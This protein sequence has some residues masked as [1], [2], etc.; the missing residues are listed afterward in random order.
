MSLTEAVERLRGDVGTQVT[1]LVQREG[2]KDPLEFTIRR[3]LISIDSV[4]AELMDDG[5]ALLKI[6]NFQEDTA[7]ELMRS[8]EQLAERADGLKGIILDLRNNPGGLLDQS[9]AVADAFLSDG[10]IVSTV[11]INDKLNEEDYAHKDN[12]LEDIPV[13]VLVNAGSASASEILAG[14]LQVH[15]RALI[16]GNRTFGKGTVQ[17]LYD[18]RDGSALKLTIAKYLAAGKEDVQSNGITPDLAMIPARISDERVDLFEN[19]VNREHELDEYLQKQPIEANTEPLFKLYYLQEEENPESISGK[20]ELAHDYPVELAHLIINESQ[21]TTRPES[22]EY[23]KKNINRFTTE[24]D[25]IIA[26]RLKDYG[27]DWEQG[28]T[29]DKPEASIEFWITQGENKIDSVVSGTEIA[30]H[31]KVTN[32][33]H[34]PFYRLLAVSESDNDWLNNL[35][36]PL[37]K[38]EPGASRTYSVPVSLPATL[39]SQVVPLSLTFHEQNNNVPKSQ[40]IPIAVRLADGPRFSYEWWLKTEND[41]IKPGSDIDITFRIDNT[42]AGPTKDA[43]INLVN[44]EGDRLFLTKGRAALD[45]IAPGESQEATLSFRLQDNFDKETAN[46]DVIIEDQHSVYTLRD[47]LKFSLNGLPSDPPMLEK[48]LPPLLNL[49]LPENPYWSEGDSYRLKGKASDDHQI[50]EIYAFVNINKVFY[51]AN[52]DSSAHEL[53][54][55]LKIPLKDGANRITVIAKDDGDLITSEQWVVWKPE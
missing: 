9:V 23:L 4:K 16:I 6:K 38:I 49:E 45:S 2:V 52:H 54:F 25:K 37:G 32:T 14:A 39:A 51:Q 1:I 40:Q 17:T 42:G 13:V 43:V 48:Q 11:G 15:D 10:I 35:E 22:I 7:S 34:G 8:T 55:N 3:A 19:K 5:V 28:N 12:I 50:K 20:V 53:P 33:G 27:I 41:Q 36:F 46:L 31:L 30:L 21:S 18:M 29:A 44:K 24:Q 26:V 47:E